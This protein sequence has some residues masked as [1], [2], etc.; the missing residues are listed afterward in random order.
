MSIFF[1]KNGR[2]SPYILYNF[3]CGDNSEF[4]LYPGVNYV[5]R[6]ASHPFQKLIHWYLQPPSR[7]LFHVFS[8]LDLVLS[9]LIIFSTS[10]FVQ[11]PI[12]LTYFLTF[13]N[14]A[15]S[16]F[17]KGG[18]IVLSTTVSFSAIKPQILFLFQD[19]IVLVFLL[20]SLFALEKTFLSWLVDVTSSYP[21]LL[22]KIIAWRL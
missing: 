21:S 20:R 15:L 8:F 7:K 14:K 18:V 2:H 13:D 9:T 5:L 11:Y 17:F 4:I 16:S 10:L 22:I 3:W 12:F 19:L 1:R 6:C